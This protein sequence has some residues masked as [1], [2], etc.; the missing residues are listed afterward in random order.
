MLGLESE[1]RAAGG[2]RASSRAARTV[3]NEP[4]SQRERCLQWGGGVR[5]IQKEPS[6]PQNNSCFC[7]EALELIKTG[8]I[9]KSI[10]QRVLRGL[11]S[12][13]RD[14]RG[15]KLTKDGGLQ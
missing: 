1:L 6:R 9:Q 4:C 13:S 3:A 15:G 8:I 5:G 2:Q 7:W 12:P 14:W 11:V 10:R